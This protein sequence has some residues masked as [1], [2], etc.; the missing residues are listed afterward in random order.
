M[1]EELIRSCT[2]D[3]AK[4]WSDIV[5]E[6]K[7]GAGTSVAITRGRLDH[8]E[9]RDNFLD[10]DEQRANDKILILFTVGL[11]KANEY[12]NMKKE[13][14]SFFDELRNRTTEIKED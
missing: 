3:V 10:Q 4:V 9:L 8:N 2:C 14:T 12:D 11:I 1:K 6:M 7:A 13:I 5:D